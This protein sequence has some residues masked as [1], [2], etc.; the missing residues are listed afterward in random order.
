MHGHH[1]S[2]HGMPRRAAPQGCASR[3]CPISFASYATNAVC[4]SLSEPQTERIS[5][6]FIHWQSDAV[7]PWVAHRVCNS[8]SRRQNVR[9]GARHLP[10]GRAPHSCRSASP[11]KLPKAAVLVRRPGRLP[12]CYA[13]RQVWNRRRQVRTMAHVD[14]G[15]RQCVS[16]GSPLQG[17][18]VSNAG[19]VRFLRKATS[20]LLQPVKHESSV[21]ASILDACCAPRQ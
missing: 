5:L 13:E 3:W 10:D 2:S 9:N 14:A 6:S 18:R 4:Q 19:P 21:E 20:I 1:H 11:I 17:R 16:C 12:G 7:A 15:A 8:E